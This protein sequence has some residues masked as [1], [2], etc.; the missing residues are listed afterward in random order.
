M[1]NDQPAFDPME[2]QT[3]PTQFLPEQAEM[4][5][6]LPTAKSEYPIRLKIEFDPLELGGAENFS[7]SDPEVEETFAVLEPEAMVA[8][9]MELLETP[10]GYTAP[11]F[12]DFHAT[13]DLNRFD[14]AA[15][16]HDDLDA[17]FAE[18][19]DSASGQSAD[20]A[21]W[22]PWLVDAAHG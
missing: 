6:E 7:D 12:E 22:C 4:P 15:E 16:T 5:D 18:L 13:D 21:V 19:A 2:E 10:E 14:S 9:P 17:L 8:V 3:S 1:T 11:Q 20:V